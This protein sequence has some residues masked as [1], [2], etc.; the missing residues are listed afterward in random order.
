MAMD[1]ESTLLSNTTQA[2]DSLELDDFP[3]V[4]DLPK[5]AQ[6]QH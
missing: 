2:T 1:A 4:N 3:D 5:L 6:L